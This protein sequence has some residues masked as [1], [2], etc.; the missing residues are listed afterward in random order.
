[1]KIIDVTDVRLFNAI[2]IGNMPLKRLV[3]EKHKLIFL[4]EIKCIAA[5]DLHLL[6][7]N[8]DLEACVIPLDNIQFFKCTYEMKSK[9]KSK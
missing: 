5:W 4:P 7:S 1:M 9:V 2:S 8:P 3:A 6:K